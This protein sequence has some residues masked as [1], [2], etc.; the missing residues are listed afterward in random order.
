VVGLRRARSLRRRKFWIGLQS[1]GWLDDDEVLL[2]AVLVV[3]DRVE[4]VTVWTL[5]QVATE[6]EGTISIKIDSQGFERQGD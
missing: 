2:R 1:S 6:C 4:S 5:D 3:T